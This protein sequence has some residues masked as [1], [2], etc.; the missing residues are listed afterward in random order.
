MI[1]DLKAS[2]GNG[3]VLELPHL[4]LGDDAI[5]LDFDMMVFNS[6]DS[7]FPLPKLEEP[8]GLDSG[9]SSP[10]DS[11][12]HYS[13]I[14]FD[15]FGLDHHGSRTRAFSTSSLG[16]DEAV[17][18]LMSTPDSYMESESDCFFDFHGLGPMADGSMFLKP[19]NLQLPTLMP[20]KVRSL[21][22]LSLAAVVWT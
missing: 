18:A 21:C 1:S 13:S 22:A 20:L 3:A 15:S 5:D 14:S 6:M 16:L 8:A 9:F 12:R 2:P 11:P 10:Q 4:D 7:D 17:S 19:G